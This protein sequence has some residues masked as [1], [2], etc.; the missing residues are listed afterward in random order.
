MKMVWLMSIAGL[1]RLI[2]IPVAL[3]QNISQN[4]GNLLMI[5]VLPKTPACDTTLV[6][7][8]VSVTQ[9]IADPFRAGCVDN[10]GDALPELNGAVVGYCTNSA[11]TFHNKCVEGG[12]VTTVRDNFCK[13]TPNLFTEN[14]AGRAGA[15]LQRIAHCESNP[16]TDSV[17]CK[18]SDFNGRQGDVGHSMPNHAK[19]SRMHPTD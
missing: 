2:Q 8:G 16:F 9:C 15:D 18:G 12:D 11:T 10:A 6:S 14:C 3:L 13:L 1:M 17:Q 19:R 5:A 4:A 7:A